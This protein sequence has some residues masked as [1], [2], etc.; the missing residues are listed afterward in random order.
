M[1]SLFR[2]EAIEANQPHW[3]GDIVV[4]QPPSARLVSCLTAAVL[5]GL[6][7][8]LGCGEYTRRTPVSG[9]LVPAA[10]LVQV[11]TNQAGIVVKRYVAEGEPVRAGQAMYAISGER[12]SGTEADTQMA[13]SRELAARRDS[14][15]AELATKQ[16]V[17]RDQERR[18]GRA[19]GKLRDELARADEQ[20]V[21]QGRRLTLEAATAA[22]YQELFNTGYVSG[23]LLKEKQ[24]QLLDQKSRLTAL[25]RERM[26]VSRGIDEKQDELADLQ[27]RHASD[28]AALTRQL[29]QNRQD[30]SAAELRRREVIVA[31]R[32]GVATGIAVEAGQTVT[33]GTALASIVPSGSR[34]QARLYAPSKAIGFI[35]V[36]DQV[37][38]RYEAFPYQRFGL[39][40]GRVVSISR[41]PVA[42]TVAL[43]AGTVQPP[44]AQYEI[45]VEL[46]RQTILVAGVERPLPPGMLLDA[47]ILSETRRLYQWLFVPFYELNAVRSDR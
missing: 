32:A 10:G 15:Q 17:L 2:R 4:I 20:I 24:G 18:I 13:I 28:A 47:D 43:N 3:L 16:E 38:L 42:V 11:Y 21:D 34:L 35:A 41:A 37:K 40:E 45:V 19:I 44:A 31:P 39:A 14:V 27:A 29:S 26:V 22:R 46:A 8:L 1:S 30:W 33:A 6:L 25:Q 36:G 9:R 5:A 23:E 7:L 12:Q